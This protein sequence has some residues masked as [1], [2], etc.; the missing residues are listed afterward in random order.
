MSSWTSNSSSNASENASESDYY[1]SDYD[2]ATEWTLRSLWPRDAKIA[3]IATIATAFVATCGFA[4]AGN[5]LVIATL[6][7][8][9]H[10]RTV[11]NTL[12]LNQSLVDLLL[13]LICMPVSLI[14][15]LMQNFIFASFVCPVV[16]YLQGASSPHYAR[17]T[18]HVVH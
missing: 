18:P 1:E 11:T 9:R 7:Q 13:A 5:A 2:W 4:C 8:Q 3:K 12:L 16:L 15:K 14:G 17:N 10:M 6:V